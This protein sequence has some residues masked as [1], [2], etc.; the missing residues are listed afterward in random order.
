MIPPP[1]CGERFG[2][3]FFFPELIIF[4]QEIPKENLWKENDGVFLCV[5]F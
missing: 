2:D 4:V 1:G 5:F 3:V